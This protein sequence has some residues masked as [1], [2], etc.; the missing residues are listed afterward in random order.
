[1][2]SGF[3]LPLL[4]RFVLI[5][6]VTA[7]PQMAVKSVMAQ[8]ASQ[9]NA[10]DRELAQHILSQVHEALKHNYYDPSFHGVDV[11]ERFSKYS[12]EI[13][14]ANTFQAAYRTIESFLIGL[15]DS[16]T[17]FIPP[18]NSNRVTYGFRIKMI[19]DQCFV[20]GLRTNSD[21]AQKL[22]LG[23][24]V[25]ALDGYTVSRQ[26]L[27]QLEYYLNFLPPRLATDF[28]LRANSGGVRK[29]SVNADLE[30]LPA[31]RPSSASLSRMHFESWQRN[32]RSRSAEQDDVFFWKFASFNEE[33]GGIEH[34]LSEARKHRALVL[35]LRENS[36]GSQ[37]NLVFVLASLFY[38]DVAV[39]KEVTRKETKNL[40]AK[41][42]GR[43][44]FTGQLVV[45]VDGRSA[46]ASE[47]LA[48]VVQIEKRGFVIGDRSA[49]SVMAARVFPLSAGVGKGFDYGVQVTVA[50]MI[51]TD[52][53]SLE[54]VGITPDE[55][56]LPTADDLATGRDPLLARAAA[57]VG[58]K[59][60]A[61]SAGKLFPIEWPSPEPLQ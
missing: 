51:M 41:S 4:S 18:P 23:D 34:M 42:R 31:R 27:W 49:G 61:T 35:D 10:Y 45:L 29:E 53:K 38:H 20:T 3:Q 52:G 36:G 58:A 7:A 60:D 33:E 5:A 43:S 46:S 47:I 13:K 6:L 16:H 17:I 19:G 55:I 59:L 32:I 11:D 44:A 12:A 50:D 37:N 54:H 57:L 25:L 9:I 8:T 28:T 30:T 40:A 14:S 21:A 56:L 22:H 24:Q 15:N 2:L 26:D 1:M 48:R 39:G